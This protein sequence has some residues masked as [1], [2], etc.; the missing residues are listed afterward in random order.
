MPDLFFDRHM[1]HLPERLFDL[2]TDLEAYPRFIP[3]CKAMEVR[4]EPSDPRVRYA[5]MTL[6]FGPLTQAYTS[7]VTADPVAHTVNA[8]AV[9]G[10]FSYL[11]KFREGGQ[12]QQI[13]AADDIGHALRRI[14]DHGT[15]WLLG[16]V[17][18]YSW[19]NLGDADALLPL[20][21]RIIS[22]GNER[23][24]GRVRIHGIEN[25]LHCAV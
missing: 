11:W 10:P 5:K 7:R 17:P 15:A 6:S 9:D 1:P 23:F 21:Q 20:V 18:D 4:N 16:T 14:V 19:S 13:G 3:N 2:V 24:Q 22:E 8:K 25:L 12:H